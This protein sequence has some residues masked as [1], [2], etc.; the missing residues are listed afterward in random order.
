MPLKGKDIL[1][2]LITSLDQLDGQIGEGLGKWNRFQSP[3]SSLFSSE[4]KENKN[5]RRARIIVEPLN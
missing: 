5:T 4:L 1:I 2:R 3:L